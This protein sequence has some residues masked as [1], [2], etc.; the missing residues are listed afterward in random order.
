MNL[1]I[2][3]TRS[4][5]DYDYACSQLNKLLSQTRRGDILVLD[6]CAPGADRIGREWAD[7]HCIEHLPFQAL[8]DDLEAPGA[9]IRTNRSGKKYNAVAGH[10]RNQKM[11]DFATHAIY[12]WSGSSS[13]TLDCIKRAEKASLPIRIVDYKRNKVYTSLKQHKEDRL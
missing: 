7:N 1:I 12:F 10:Q 4:F 8:W 11:V 9:V 6:G 5:K 3:G 2:A 13:G